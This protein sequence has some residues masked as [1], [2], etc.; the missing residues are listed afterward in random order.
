[1][2]DKLKPVS[3][4]EESSVENTPVYV[5]VPSLSND[6]RGVIGSLEQTIPV[7]GK[8]IKA[9]T[10]AIW[11][12]THEEVVT[13][14]MFEEALYLIN[15]KIAKESLDKSISECRTF[16]DIIYK[17]LSYINRL[18][19]EMNQYNDPSANEF[20]VHYNFLLNE[21]ANFQSFLLNDVNKIHLL[22]CLSIL[23]VLHMAV[24]RHKV[25]HGYVIYNV[26][27]NQLES[28]L[29]NIWL[30]E[31]NSTY[32]NYKKNIASIY[33]DWNAWRKNQIHRCRTSDPK[34]NYGVKINLDK[35][36]AV[37]DELVD[38]SPLFQGFCSSS[39]KTLMNQVTIAIEEKLVNA[40]I[41]QIVNYL[42]LSFEL[43]RF[44][45]ANDDLDIRNHFENNTGL[46]SINNNMPEPFS[47][48]RNIQQGMLSRLTHMNNTAEAVYE[49]DLTDREKDKAGHV[50]AIRVNNDKYDKY[51]T[52]NKTS[53]MQ[54]I[55]SD[56]KEG[57]IYEQF[58][59]H[60]KGRI[61]DIKL[62]ENNPEKTYFIGVHT[63]NGFDGFY[64]LFNN[65]I[66]YVL[67]N[68]IISMPD[69]AA[70]ENYKPGGNNAI[71]GTAYA[72]VSMD[73]SGLALTLSHPHV[74]FHF[75]YK[76]IPLLSV[77]L[78]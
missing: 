72:L 56:N 36:Y 70:K 38:A 40:S 52:P 11:P 20:L 54:L 24:L 50:N 67:S 26:N 49:L 39:N 64:Y 73:S 47:G 17:N 51:A 48:L 31:L 4:S 37:I 57:G 53:A 13:V 21:L 46:Y 23:S 58:D 68:D 8:L 29:K 6:V 69:S 41:A 28:R 18:S 60:Y 59:S 3:A 44:K 77:D 66:Y 15:R 74:T 2:L 42:S 14:N 61:S 25:T 35:Q 30:V 22:P 78:R 9:I 34:N 45:L 63:S 1:M 19:T 32:D 5:D 65:T 7:F 27:A 71:I 55:Y 76:K 43:N 75:E 12:K 10:F 33:D 16:L 62:P